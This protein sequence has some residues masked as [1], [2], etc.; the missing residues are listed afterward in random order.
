MSSFY[1]PPQASGGGSVTY[2]LAIPAGSVSSP[3]IG[4][5][6][7]TSTGFYSPAA[8]ELAIAVNGV[9][10][11][12]FTAN[13]FGGQSIIMPSG[14]ST[15]SIVPS[16]TGTLPAYAGTFTA[17]SDSYQAGYSASSSSSTGGP[18]Y[19]F[20]TSSGTLGSPVAMASF[21]DLGYLVWHGYNSSAYVN[22]LQLSGY[23]TGAWTT[24]NYGCGLAISGT[25][26]GTTALSQL[27]AVQDGFMQLQEI[28]TP[29]F[30]TSNPGSG[31]LNLYVKSDG[32]IYS[33]N[34]SNIETQLTGN[35]VS[36]TNVSSN[37]LFSSDGTYDIGGPYPTA[38]ARPA[39]IW[40]KT[41]VVA[42]ATGDT[43]L[44]EDTLQLGPLVQWQWSPGNVEL[45]LNIGSNP[46]LFIESAT[47]TD[48]GSITVG[49]PS[50]SGNGAKAG[51]LTSQY[52]VPAN[53]QTHN[54]VGL[55]CHSDLSTGFG[56]YAAG[57][58]GIASAG[59]VAFQVATGTICT[60]GGA[61]LTPQHVLNTLTAA[62]GSGAG[63]FTNLP[64]GY[65]GN[66]T[67]YIQ[68]TINGG[69]H[70]IPYW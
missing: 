5:S 39:Y 15:V 65:S 63:T 31:F 30:A 58:A 27:F 24:S 6:G 13:S 37:I 44:F 32:N 29:T 69:T 52:Q 70:V 23:T 12:L 3:S 64:T 11:S 40:A 61:S 2:P 22:A 45:Y 16:G 49:G 66:P 33:Q 17:A 4:V 19:S 48:Y 21:Q 25:H 28:T 34:S 43:Y 35:A 41:A 9:E 54:T 67:G 42:G 51:F 1:W 14:F 59:V 62:T 38:A 53:T 55:G 47:A 20:Y 60:I 10:N 36:L 50:S 18:V 57:N 8:N 68:I 56:V 46:F 7:S 26:S